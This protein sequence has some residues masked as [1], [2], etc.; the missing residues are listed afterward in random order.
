MK[1]LFNLMFLLLAMSPALFGQVRN[2]TGTVTSSE[3]GAPIP[4][5]TVVLKGTSTGVI[6]DANGS[7][8]QFLSIHPQEY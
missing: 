3:D 5:A 8:L 7:L 2:L 4:G 1:K 6:T